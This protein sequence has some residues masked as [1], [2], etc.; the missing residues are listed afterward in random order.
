MFG[1]PQGIA[2][3]STASLRITN[4]DWLWPGIQL[5]NK[6]LT[7]NLHVG[8]MENSSHFT[9]YCNIIEQHYF[10]TE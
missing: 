9:V 6:A 1:P 5:V 3:L 10:C 4:L 2:W 7:H 8:E